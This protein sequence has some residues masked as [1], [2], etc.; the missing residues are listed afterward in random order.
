MPVLLECDPDE[1][2][3]RVVAPERAAR[4]KLVDPV[5]MQE[6]LDEA[7]PLPP[8]DDIRRIDVTTLPPPEAARAILELLPR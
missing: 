1:V 6:I 3:R 2:L 7:V 4:H 8:W 5:R